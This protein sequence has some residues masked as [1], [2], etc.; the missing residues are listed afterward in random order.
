MLSTVLVVGSALTGPAYADI[1]RVD[2][3]LFMPW[4]GP[5]Q[6]VRRA[7]EPLVGRQCVS[8]VSD[9]LGADLRLLGCHRQRHIQEILGCSRLELRS[10]DAR[11]THVRQPAALRK[12][13]TWRPAWHESVILLL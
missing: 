1:H 11:E 9:I 5:L 4:A 12:I 10:K 6:L 13:R 2:I 3:T 7:L 8:Q